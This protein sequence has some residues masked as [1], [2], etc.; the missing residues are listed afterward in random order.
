M[1]NEANPPL[2]FFSNSFETSAPVNG[3]GGEYRPAADYRTAPDA[4]VSVARGPGEEQGGDWKTRMRARMNDRRF[5]SK[6]GCIS[7]F[8][9]FFLI[10]I[11]V[12]FT[13]DKSNSYK[14][15]VSAFCMEPPQ[16]GGV[17]GPA[18]NFPGTSACGLD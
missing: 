13:Y 15:E 16:G 9:I 14:V 10:L 17:V 7:C 3:G 5:M 4:D 1:R 2:N 6:V 11:I 18:G 8:F 12:A